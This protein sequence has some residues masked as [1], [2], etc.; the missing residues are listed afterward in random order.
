[1]AESS[2]IVTSSPVRGVRVIVLDRPQKRN[3]LSKQMIKDLLEALQRASDDP[4]IKAIVIAGT[5]PCFSAG[6]DLK[7]IAEMD[8]A[9]ARSCRYLEDLCE[10]MASVGK[11]LFAAVDGFA[12]G[13]GFELALMCDFIYAS[14]KAQFLLP[15]VQLGLIPG[16]GGTQ[17][18]T[19]ALGKFRAMKAILL[20][21]PISSDEALSCGLV[22][23]I[24]DD[25]HVLDK[26]IEVAASLCTKGSIATQL[27]KEA[28]CRADDMCR[29]DKF[30]RNLYYFA[31]GTTEK[32]QT[33]NA[34]LKK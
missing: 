11:P 22:C 13:G 15:E 20:G 8:A 1:M 27:A 2:L 17:R 7:E 21:A 23:D 28:I 26:T 32:N 30:E 4:G 16:A 19:A 31:F 12:L 29:D 18:L 24:F 10:G 34:F 6:A 33:V 14:P 5:G 3:A 9:A 25:G